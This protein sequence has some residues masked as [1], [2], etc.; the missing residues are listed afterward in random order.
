MYQDAHDLL[1]REDVPPEAFNALMFPATPVP[2]PQLT[3]DGSLAFDPAHTYRGY[4][5]VAVETGRF[6]DVKE[7]ETVNRSVGTSPN[8]EQR[9]RT[10]VFETRFRPRFENGEPRR[11]DRF[12]VRYYYDYNEWE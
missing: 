1:V 7:A 8:V 6:G 5:D 11:S 12:D 9:A 3:S 10:H 2:L 4:V